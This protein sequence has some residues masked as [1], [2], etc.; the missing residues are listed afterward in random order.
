MHVPTRIILIAILIAVLSGACLALHIEASQNVLRI[1][2]VGR[3]SPFVGDRSPSSTDDLILS[4]LCDSLYQLRK[5]DGV[6]IPV[7]AASWPV[8]DENARSVTVIMNTSF[9]PYLAIPQVIEAAARGLAARVPVESGITVVADATRNSLRFSFRDD[10]SAFWNLFAFTPIWVPGLEGTIKGAGSPPYSQS[11]FGEGSCRLIPNTEGAPELLIVGY[12]DEKSLAAAF[13]A[14]EID[15]M[16]T[17][18]TKQAA[19]V[20]GLSWQS[21]AP[22]VIALVFNSKSLLF[23]D[24]KARFAAYEALDMPYLLLRVLQGA[25]T[26]ANGLYFRYKPAT[27]YDTASVSFFGVK[28]SILIDSTQVSSLEMLCALMIESWWEKKGALVSITIPKDANELTAAIKGANF[29]AIVTSAWL[30]PVFRGLVRT[31]YS[32]NLSSLLWG[33]WNGVERQE[34]VRTVMYPQSYGAMLSAALKLET[35]MLD[36]CSVLPLIK[37][38]ISENYRPDLFSSLKQIP[39]QPMISSMRDLALIRVT[40]SP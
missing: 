14:S 38:C 9:D 6:I 15:Y 21:E 35:A 24:I 18:L 20:R 32:G 25:A 29:D 12:N 11:E 37:P 5:A 22:A 7:L 2:V 17:G 34:L 3:V 19:S 31:G 27:T 16:K 10:A 30:Q 4:L 39:G 33:G 8:F 26:S 1:G 36:S 40:T 13:S 23:S 28:L